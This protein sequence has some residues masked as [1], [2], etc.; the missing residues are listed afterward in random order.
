MPRRAGLFAALALGSVVAGT[1][2]IAAA[3]VPLDGGVALEALGVAAAVG[4]LLVLGVLA[5]R[6]R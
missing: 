3:D 4:S 5:A 6:P 2:V 1:L